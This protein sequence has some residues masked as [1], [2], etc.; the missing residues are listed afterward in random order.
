MD[1]AASKPNGPEVGDASTVVTI[2]DLLITNDHA[3]GGDSQLGGGGAVFVGARVDATLDGV[4]FAGTQASGG[5]AV[6][7]NNAEGGGGMLANGAVAGGGLAPCRRALR[8]ET[9]G[10]GRSRRRP[11]R[12]WYQRRK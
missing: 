3:K 8:A 2:R 1:A 7:G 6:I 5:N 4:S 12:R 10:M 11:I 9:A